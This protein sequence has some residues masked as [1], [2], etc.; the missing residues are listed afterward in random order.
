MKYLLI[1]CLLIFNTLLSSQSYDDFIG[2]G[3]N[4]D[5]I[6]S[7]SST[8]NRP[9]WSQISNGN[10]TL[11][12]SGLDWDRT[13]AAR[14]LSQATIGF[15]ES[16]IDNVLEMGIEPWIDYQMQKPYTNYLDLMNQVH[17][18][19]LSLGGNPYAARYERQ[20]V[21]YRMN[22]QKD[23]FLREKISLA[24]S[25]ILV[26]SANS[27]VSQFIN[28]PVSYFDVLKSNAFGN[29]EEM[30]LEVSLHPAMGGFLSHMSNKKADT[31]L[32]IFP[33]ENYAREVMQLF[34]IGLY[35]LNIDGSPVLDQN[36][37]KIRTY[38]NHHIAELA[39]VFTGLGPGKAKY[40]N[41]E[42]E[43]QLPVWAIDYT[44]PMKAFEEH[45]DK[46]TK[47]LI[48]G[49]FLPDN[50]SVMEDVEQAINHLFN[51]QNVGPFLARRLIQHLVTSNPSP[52]YI[53]RVA[54]KFNNNGNGI[55][56]DMASV[57]KQILLDEEA[58]SCDYSTN[59]D[60][61][62]LKKPSERMIQFIRN[63]GFDIEADSIWNDGENLWWATSYRV[64][65]APSVFNFHEPDFAP[66]GEIGSNDLVAPEFQLFDAKNSVG[67]GNIIYR[68]F[69]LWEVFGRNGIKVNGEVDENF[70]I[71]P[72]LSS[73]IQ[74]AEDPEVLINHLDINFCGGKMTQ[75]TRDVLKTLLLS[76]NDTIAANDGIV[77]LNT[78][79]SILVERVKQAL[80]V[81]TL[82]PEYNI[83]K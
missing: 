23:D 26:F 53:Q 18:E 50:Q 32:N 49:I 79:E 57:I 83:L 61:G 38:S 6:V 75:H 11:D 2:A 35:Q 14:F 78:E 10:K 39:R 68:Q 66:N 31:L 60:F 59:P 21:W 3:H 5:I 17:P 19:W 45:H 28:G 40:E 51:H 73:L 8:T 42:G 48:N 52:A 4:R 9:N 55:R 12:G 80:T 81:V 74:Y 29:Y 7:S 44:Y 25:E 41:Y 22:M 63:V 71:T 56:G 24:L 82:C 20:T 77:T 43:F 67:Y 69:Y 54:E 72:K 16:L 15:E 33:D 27:E 1:N 62:R 47:E 36:D 34:S 30:L 65:H 13:Q 76:I 46:G 64:W 37:N 58:R 70:N